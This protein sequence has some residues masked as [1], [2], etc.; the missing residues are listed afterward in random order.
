MSH[1]LAQE[2]LMHLLNAL[3]QARYYLI[4]DLQDTFCQTPPRMAVDRDEI[5]ERILSSTSDEGKAARRVP[6]RCR[7]HRKRPLV[8]IIKENQ[9]EYN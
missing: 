7:R 1:V 8:E 3:Y 9:L 6:I 5:A 4:N 2:G